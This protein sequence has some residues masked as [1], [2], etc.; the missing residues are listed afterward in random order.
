MQELQNSQRNP[1]KEERSW[2]NHTSFFFNFKT[3]YRATGLLKK[4]DSKGHIL[5][6]SIY[7]KS[8]E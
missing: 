1:E 3:H 6:N 7:M 8:P 2:K 4:L 5:D